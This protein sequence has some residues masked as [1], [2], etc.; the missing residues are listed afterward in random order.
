M[1]LRKQ[2]IV[3]QRDWSEIDTE[4]HS[5]T[6]TLTIILHSSSVSV[7]LNL[8]SVLPIPSWLGA[9]STSDGHGHC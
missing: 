6:P 3:R 9:M 1:Q 8:V 7:V 5:E 2:T 4:V